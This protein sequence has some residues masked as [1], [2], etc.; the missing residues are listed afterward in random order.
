MLILRTSAAL[1]GG[2]PDGGAHGAALPGELA[3][4]ADVDGEEAS[5]LWTV[6]CAPSPGASHR[7]KNLPNSPLLPSPLPRPRLSPDPFPPPPPPP[8]PPLLPLSPPLLFHLRVGRQIAEA[9]G[10]LE[11]AFEVGMAAGAAARWIAVP[12]SRR[13]GSSPSST[14]STYAS[15]IASPACSR[16]PRPRRAAG[17]RVDSVMP[18]LRRSDRVA[19]GCEASTQLAAS[20]E[21]VLVDR[22]AVRA[23]SQRETSIETS[24]SATATKT[25]RWRSVSSSAGPAPQLL[26]LLG[27]LRRA[28]REGVG[29]LL[30]LRLLLRRLPPPGV[31]RHL[32]RD[33]EDHEL[34]GPGREAARAAE[35]V[36]L[37]KDVHQRVVR[38]L[39]GEVVELR[40]GDRPE[41]VAAAGDLVLR[42]PQEQPVQVAQGP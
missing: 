41:C 26:A 22:V 36:E 17:R 1:D 5:G 3:G 28:R 11:Q 8:P 25:S 39:L 20:V 12:G 18:L 10:G 30:P 31:P 40:A 37:G 7:V 35:L 15:R 34:V 33:V 27:L 24:L 6:K 32:A 38:R 19:R 9:P 4:E 13:L 2:L 42:H 29:D 21:Q 14:S 16:R 23:E